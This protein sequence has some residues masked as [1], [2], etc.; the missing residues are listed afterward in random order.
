MSSNKALGVILLELGLWERVDQLDKG[1][2]LAPGVAVD[3]WAV[4]QRIMK[5]ASRRLGF[6]AGERYRDVVVGCLSGEWGQEDSN[7]VLST[8]APISFEEAVKS[9]ERVA[10]EL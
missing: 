4:H 10:R 1:A 5:H 3:P 9:L 7:G 8:K 2:V 6:Y